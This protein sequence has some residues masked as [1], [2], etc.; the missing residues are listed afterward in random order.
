M[1]AV[2][3]RRSGCRPGGAGLAPE[4]LGQAPGGF[5]RGGARPHRAGTG[6]AATRQASQVRAPRRAPL[7]EPM[8][9]IPPPN[10]HSHWDGA[11]HRARTPERP[12]TIALPRWPGDA[13]ARAPP[14]A[15]SR[16]RGSRD[17]LAGTISPAFGTRL[18]RY[19]SGALSVQCSA[20][21]TNG[22]QAC[23]PNPASSLPLSW[24]LPPAHTMTRAKGR[25]AWRC[26][27][28]AWR[29]GSARGAGHRHHA[30]GSG[31]GRNL[32]H[33]RTSPSRTRLGPRATAF[34]PGANE[35][36]GAARGARGVAQC[37][38][39][40]RAPETYPTR[41]VCRRGVGDWPPV[42]EQPW[43][44]PTRPTCGG[45]RRSSRGS[46]PSTPPARA[47]HGAMPSSCASAG[48]Y[49]AAP[50]R[51]SIPSRSGAKPLP[52]GGRLPGA[53]AGSRGY[54]CAEVRR[55]T[56]TSG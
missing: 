35:A 31:S 22:G 10:K 53:A 23:A 4:A 6:S 20:S 48:G 28:S 32:G 43:N 39:P 55:P 14:Q 9:P 7:P 42:R 56:G 37:A 50:S 44:R 11:R 38:R 34:T 54:Y 36:E 16:L 24:Q 41:S 25:G 27:R 51:P 26:S 47:A 5:P 2:G 21:I 3:Q 8:Q 29:V 45:R 19:H 30:S 33:L 13:A 40:L 46:R 49:L 15:R 17:R 1:S 18:G 52:S 12:S